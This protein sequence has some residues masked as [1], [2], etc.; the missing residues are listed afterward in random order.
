MKN[1]IL[2]ALFSVMLSGCQPSHNVVSKTE[3]D[4]TNDNSR[5]ELLPSDGSYSLGIVKDKETGREYLFH[6]YGGIVELNKEV[7]K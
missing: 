3:P 4:S 7:R 1:L 5:L 2:C 6:V